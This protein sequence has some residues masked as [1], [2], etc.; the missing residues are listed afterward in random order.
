MFRTRQFGTNRGK[1]GNDKYTTLYL[2]GFGADTSTTITDYAYRRTAKAVT[3]AGNVQI[4]TDQYYYGNS[5]ILFDGTGDYLTLLDS[6]DWYFGTSPFTLDLFVRFAALPAASNYMV[7]MGQRVDGDNG[8]NFYLYN[9]A[10]TYQWNF[11]N[12]VATTLTIDATG[13]A[14]PGLLVNTWYH[15]AVVRNGNDFMIF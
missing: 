15:I 14:S 6:A 3:C 13:K 8:W 5:S 7:I 2:P 9:N 4:D 10:G 12:Q 11:Y 1:G